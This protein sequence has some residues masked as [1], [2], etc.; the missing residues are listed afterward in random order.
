MSPLTMVPDAF[1]KI[2]PTA[3]VSFPEDAGLEAWHG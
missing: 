2:F 3:N 1:L